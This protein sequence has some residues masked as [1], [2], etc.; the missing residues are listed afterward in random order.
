MDRAGG[1]DFLLLRVS[2]RRGARIYERGL[3]MHFV[4]VAVGA[5]FPSLMT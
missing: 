5:G 4:C 3:S 1:C 2:L